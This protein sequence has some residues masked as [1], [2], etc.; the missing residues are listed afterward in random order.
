MAPFKKTWEAVL[1]DEIGVE[2]V[3]LDCLLHEVPVYHRAIRSV[4]W[5]VETGIDRGCLG[6]RGIQEHETSD[7]NR[8]S[9]LATVALEVIEV[10]D[11]YGPWTARDVTAWTSGRK[12]PSPSRSGDEVSLM[13]M[14]RG[15]NNGKVMAADSQS[16]S[17]GLA[18]PISSLRIPNG[19][20]LC[21]TAAVKHGR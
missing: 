16:W 1:S 4:Q 21:R 15:S 11:K 10:N 17:V 7:G 5:L 14:A 9:D 13:Q 12:M 6:M 3:L 18:C 8:R 2:S 20:C 19:D